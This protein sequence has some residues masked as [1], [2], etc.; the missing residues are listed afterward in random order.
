MKLQ[1]LQRTQHQQQQ[2]CVTAVTTSQVTQA[3]P[4]AAGPH[5]I[6]EEHVL[7]SQLNPDSLQGLTPVLKTTSSQPGPAPEPLSPHNT[8]FNT[9]DP[10][11]PQNLTPDSSD[12]QSKLFLSSVQHQ[13]QL[14]PFS[15]ERHAA[16][17]PRRSRVSDHITSKLLK[18]H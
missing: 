3:G 4:T 1:Q 11:L 18:W 8:S 15:T 5:N 9:L 12:W 7:L 10:G 17:S 16:E 13:K 2:R 6:S 14:T